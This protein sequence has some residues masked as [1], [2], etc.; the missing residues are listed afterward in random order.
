M[1][2]FDYTKMHVDTVA[3]L[4]S[5]HSSPNVV[6]YDQVLLEQCGE[7]TIFMHVK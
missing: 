5:A 7:A 2:Q 3:K 4:E 1:R 6:Y